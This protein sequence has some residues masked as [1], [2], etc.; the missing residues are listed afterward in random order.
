MHEIRHLQ[1]ESR[2]L[3]GKCNAKQTS[4]VPR[5]RIT[6]IHIVHT[7]KRNICMYVYTYVCIHICIY[8]YD[9]IPIVIIP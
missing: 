8:I 2:S 1:G 7:V 3:R 5:L 6:Q 9:V 4:V